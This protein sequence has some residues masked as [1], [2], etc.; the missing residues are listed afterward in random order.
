MA[1]PK[2]WTFAPAVTMSLAMGFLLIV[3]ALLSAVTGAFAGV[4]GPEAAPGHQAAA[5]AVAAVK[6]VA[7]VVSAEVPTAERP[8]A[9]PQQAIE[10]APAAAPAEAAPLDTDRLTE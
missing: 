3:S 6:S 10:A 1:D 8:A 4:R 2:A 7:V 9:E 5:E